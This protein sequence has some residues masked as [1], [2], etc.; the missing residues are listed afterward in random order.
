MVFIPPGPG[1]IAEKLT[2]TVSCSNDRCD[3]DLALFLLGFQKRR[4]FFAKLQTSTIIL[5][6]LVAD[7]KISSS[8]EPS[9]NQNPTFLGAI[10]LH[11]LVQERR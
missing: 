8:S 2:F 3:S 1:S 11:Y 10:Q 7:D 9:A 6:P 4:L 5:G